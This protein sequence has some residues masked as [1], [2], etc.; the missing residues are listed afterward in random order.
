MPVL[1]TDDQAKAHSELLS[2][3]SN[4]LYRLERELPSNNLVT[5]LAYDAVHLASA[6]SSMVDGGGVVEEQGEDGMVSAIANLQSFIP[7]AS[8]NIMI[9]SIR[10]QTA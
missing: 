10:T 4:R 8:I 1:L 7:H 2:T 5:R 3:M 9:P 6:W